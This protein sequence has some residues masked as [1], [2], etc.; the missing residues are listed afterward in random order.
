MQKQIYEEHDET[1]EN[2]Q[3]IVSG[4]PKNTSWWSSKKCKHAN[5]WTKQVQGDLISVSKS[6]VLEVYPKDWAEDI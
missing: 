4:S 6:A 3:G 1:Q 5:T 2:M